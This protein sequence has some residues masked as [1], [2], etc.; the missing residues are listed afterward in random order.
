M[1]TQC[2]SVSVWHNE[3]TWICNTDTNTEQHVSDGVSAMKTQQSKS[4]QVRPPSYFPMAAKSLKKRKFE[5]LN[6]RRKEGE[7]RRSGPM[8][9]GSA[10]VWELRTSVYLLTYRFGLKKK[11]FCFF[12]ELWSFFCQWR[13][14]W[15]GSRCYH[16]IGCVF[17]SSDCS[18]S[19]L[20][21]NGWRTAGRGKKL[22]EQAKK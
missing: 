6:K 7:G 20:I 12:L 17:Y 18:G 3:Q 10:D 16:L 19:W 4:I 2:E 14:C 8:L 15:N 22:K 11:H 1:T 21:C 5:E 13:L 9:K